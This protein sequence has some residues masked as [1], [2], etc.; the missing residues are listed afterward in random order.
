MEVY[1]LN[2]LSG[3]RLVSKSHNKG[4]EEYIFVYEGEISITIDNEII[5]LKEGDSA[6]YRADLPHEYYNSGDDLCKAYMIIYYM[7]N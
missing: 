3:G 2:F 7:N 6:R 5:S 4:V 1:I